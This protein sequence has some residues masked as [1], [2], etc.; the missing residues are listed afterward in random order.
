MNGNSAGQNFVLYRKIGGLTDFFI[1][2]FNENYIFSEN[3]LLKFDAKRIVKIY[4]P[5]QVKHLQLK[6]FR[7]VFWLYTCF[8]K[9]KTI[10]GKS[11]MQVLEVRFSCQEILSMF[12]G[13][14]LSGVLFFP[15]SYFALRTSTS[16]IFIIYSFKTKFSIITK[17]YQTA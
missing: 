17:Y 2:N 10:S 3:H 1:Q 12:S 6:F 4:I 16:I 11:A 15:I 7:S 13:F 14:L 9:S 5:L 8:V